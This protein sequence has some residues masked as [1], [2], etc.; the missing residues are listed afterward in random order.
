MKV[1]KS[2][3]ETSLRMRLKGIPQN[4]VDRYVE[5]YK[6]MI[7]DRI[8]EGMDEDAAVAAVGHPDDIE[9]RIR[10]ERMT[11]PVSAPADQNNQKRKLSGG[12]IAAIIIGCIILSPLLLGL[13]GAA[14]GIVLGL[15]GAAFGLF[16]AAI[17]IYVSFYVI[18]A[19][20][21]GL[22]FIS[23]F[24]FTA[25]LPANGLFMLGAGFF[26]AGISILL[27]IALNR[28]LAV[29]FRAI[30]RLFSRIDRRFAR[31]GMV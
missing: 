15:L 20:G 27:I 22:M 6:E 17:A 28:L 30:G 31:G 2:E 21:F 7:D 24:S 18:T 3:F 4:E 23:I 29:I 1:T 5:Y 9:A 19:A 16:A 11:P 25:G 12:A 26:L 14:I 10:A 8:D 13:L